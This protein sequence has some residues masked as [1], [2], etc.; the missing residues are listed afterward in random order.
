MCLKA[1]KLGELISKFMAVFL[2]K[3]LLLSI[4]KTRR[5]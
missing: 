2:I 4:A 1:A 3:L 5:I